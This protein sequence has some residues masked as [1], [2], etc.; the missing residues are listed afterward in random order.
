M[1]LLLIKIVKSGK[2]ILSKSEKEQQKRIK[3]LKSQNV[4]FLILNGECKHPVRV[5]GK[6][7][8]KE[9]NNKQIVSKNA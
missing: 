3:E 9:I 8:I 6:I 7:K 1:K 2:V 4:E 5:E